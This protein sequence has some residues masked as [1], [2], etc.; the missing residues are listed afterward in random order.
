M[1][2]YEVLVA[3]ADGKSAWSELATG[4]TPLIASVAFFDEC[5]KAGEIDGFTAIHLYDKFIV[6][7]DLIERLF[8]RLAGT[9]ESSMHA[10][11]DPS[12]LGAIDADDNYHVYLSEV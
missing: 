6:K 10:S 1:T 12:S 5:A 3:P 7:G 4:M 11:I 2:W 8:E 9:I